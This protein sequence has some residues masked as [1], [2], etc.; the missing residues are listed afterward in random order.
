[1]PSFIEKELERI[2]AAGLKRRLPVIE[3]PQSA[4]V[5][6]DGRDALLLCSN[7]YL[8]LANDPLLKEA[9]IKAI[10]KYGTGAGAS[11]LVSGNMEPHRELEERIRRFKSTEAALLFNSG[12]NANLGC[13]T[14]L[15]DRNTEIFSDRLNH[16]SIADACVLSRA[17]VRRYPNRDADSLERL[18]KKSPAR[19]KLIVTDGVFSMDGTI[20]PLMELVALSERFGATLIIDDAHATGVIG[21]GGKG[22]LEH[23]GIKDNPSIVRMGTL[24]KALGSFGAFIAGSKALMELLTSKARPF[25]FT[26]ALPPAVCAASSKAIE[27][28]EARPELVERLGENEQRLREGLNGMGLDTM[29]SE[30]PIIP[31]AVGDAGR[32]VAL[33]QRLLD[34]GVFIQA[35]RPPTVPAGSSRLRATVTAAH[36][37]DDIETAL[38]AIKEAVNEQRD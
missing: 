18:L 19:R 7:D 1:M 12:Y 28:L 6:V 31:I 15:S 17:K 5:R 30:T 22:S 21:P 24:G 2:E 11:R 16:A 36:T 9:A 14:A 38:K 26:T 37:K 20:A 27:I 4:R 8:G 25:I 29:G 34:A 10:E 13:I 32:A 33:S 35:I 3:G 23:F